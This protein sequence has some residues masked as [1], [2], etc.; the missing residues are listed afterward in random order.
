MFTI[1]KRFCPVKEKILSVKLYTNMHIDSL[2]ETALDEKCIL[3][4]KFDRP[5]GK[6][7]KKHCHQIAKDGYIPLHR[8]FSVFLFNS[9]GDLLIQKRSATKITFPSYYTNTCCSHPLAEIDGESEEMN[10]LGIRR[11][12][13]RRLCYEL[14]IPLIEVQLQDFC[15]LTRIHYHATDDEIWGEHEIDYVLFL[16][17][18]RVTLN[19]N[20]NE[21]SEIQ[22]ISKEHMNNFV[23]NIKFPLTPWFKLILEHQLPLWWNN[24]NVLHKFQNHSTIHRFSKL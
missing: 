12:A 3:V 22:W 11:A 10:A 7:T 19:P 21:V 13:Q 8:A 6:A 14:G 2:Q 17:L 24:L 23:K 15:Y 9:N 18:N 20:P 16:Q 1:F 5:I 4:D